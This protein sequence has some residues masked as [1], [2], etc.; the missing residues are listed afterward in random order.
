ML[1]LASV[2]STNQPKPRHQVLHRQSAIDHPQLTIERF[3][4]RKDNLH[5]LF[6]LINAPSNQKSPT[7]LHRLPRPPPRP[8]SANRCPRSL[9]RLLPAPLRSSPLQRIVLPS[10]LGRSPSLRNSLRPSPRPRSS[11]RLQRKSNRVRMPTARASF[12]LASRSS[13]A[14]GAMWEVRGKVVWRW[15][16]RCVCQV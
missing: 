10:L 3:R 7:N 15:R 11:G 2:H 8:A 4:A 6:Y 1:L 16:G 9:P 12:L 5:R 13:T 14:A